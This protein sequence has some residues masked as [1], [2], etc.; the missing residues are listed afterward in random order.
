MWWKR[1]LQRSDYFPFLGLGPP[2][3]KSVLMHLYG[4]WFDL[5]C[6][7]GKGALHFSHQQCANRLC[8]NKVRKTVKIAIAL[9]EK[10]KLSRMI[11]DFYILCCPSYNTEG[12]SIRRAR[13]L[14]SLV[15]ILFLFW[16]SSIY[17]FFILP[18]APFADSQIK[19]YVLLSEYVLV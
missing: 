1:S 16:S 4:V 7:L 3:L 5:S 9:K 10:I 6:L 14:G 2:P 12:S 17:R 15:F 8:S 13:F 11:C 18:F 19:I